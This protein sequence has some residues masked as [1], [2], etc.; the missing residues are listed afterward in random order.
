MKK[1]AEANPTTPPLHPHICT[2]FCYSPNWQ[3]YLLRVLQRWSFQLKALDACSSTQFPKLESERERER[4]KRDTQWSNPITTAESL[5]SAS[6][7]CHKST[8]IIIIII[9]HHVAFFSP[10]IVRLS[11][12]KAGKRHDFSCVPAERFFQRFIRQTCFYFKK[13]STYL[14]SAWWRQT[15]AFYP[16]CNW[17]WGKLIKS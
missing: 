5:Y 9:N 15:K 4:E 1:K 6:S 12:S 14:F 13:I 17:S 2:P 7:W 3:M 8:N 16:A 11:K 10:L